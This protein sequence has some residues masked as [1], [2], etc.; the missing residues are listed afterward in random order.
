MKKTSIK[1]ER[2]CTAFHEAGHFV[3]RVRLVPEKIREKIS[4]KRRY[5]TLGR[6]IEETFYWDSEELEDYKKEILILFSG[7]AAHVEFNKKDQK[8][9][10]V[11]A[12]DDNQKAENLL[13]EMG[14]KGKKRIAFS[15]DLR[16]VAKKI[17]RQNWKAIE[18]VAK[19]LLI[20]EEM[21]GDE[22]ELIISHID[23][24]PSAARALFEYR[25]FKKTLRK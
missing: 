11:G 8:R 2:S 16:E 23:G 10:W 20:V 17:V 5:G 4:I 12:E 9:A 7:Y 22:G 14:L 19:E 6:S 13:E 25:R 21:S 3:I 18:E 1:N 24:D 15:N